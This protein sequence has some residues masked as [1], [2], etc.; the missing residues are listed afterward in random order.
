M[1]PMLFRFRRHFHD[2][3]SRR[4]IFAA[5]AAAPPPFSRRQPLIFAAA[6][7]D[8]RRFF[9]DSILAI[10]SL[11]AY[12]FF[13]MPRFSAPDIDAYAAA[14]PALPR[15]AAPYADDAA[16][17]AFLIADAADFH[18]APCRRCH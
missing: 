18:A 5:T 2:F 13:A 14:M 4:D 8:F 1:P 16:A 17:S 10:F 11:D 7:T 15:D 12:F 3:A 9:A 6:V